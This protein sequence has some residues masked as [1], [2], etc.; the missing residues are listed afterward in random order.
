[1]YRHII[2]LSANGGND[3]LQKPQSGPIANP[4]PN[5]DTCCVTY[6]GSVYLILSVGFKTPRLTKLHAHLHVTPKPDTYCTG[7][8]WPDTYCTVNVQEIK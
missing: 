2:T 3:P 1:M 7:N 6:G 8:D 5:S 4:K